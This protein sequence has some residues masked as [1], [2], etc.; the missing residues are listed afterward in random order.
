MLTLIE[1]LLFA[2]RREGFSISTAQ[3]IDAVK[4]IELV[5]F[6]DRGTVR[7]ALQAIVVHQAS[8]RER[9]SAA[10]DRFFSV[11]GAHAGDLF[12][13]LLARGFDASEI[14]ML[15]ELVDRFAER[16]SSG[17]AAI[18]ALV[19]PPSELDHLLSIARVRREVD[20]MTSPSQ[21]G[22]FRER[23]SDTLG[24]GAASTV[25]AAIGRAL[26][27]ALGERGDALREALARE[28][29][30]MKGRIHAHVEERARAI[31]TDVERP[32]AFAS[33]SSDEAREMRVAVRRIAE[34]LRGKA[35]VRRRRAR[36]GRIDAARTIRRSFATGG[37][38]FALIR[39][40][41][42][43]D[44]PKLVVVCDISESVRSASSFMLEF[45]AVVSDLL[46]DVRSFVFVSDLA[47]TS[48]LFATMPPARA[49]SAIAS[50]SVISL[51]ATSSYGRALSLLEQATR[52]GLDCRTTL[53]ILG[54]GRTNHKA[55]GADI[56]AR[57]ARRARAVLWI[58]PEAR[59]SW[60]SGD[61]RMPVYAR[62]ATVLEA[63]TVR[64]L[65][66]AA[67]A[68]LAVR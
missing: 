54:D 4:A 30:E 28:I 39:R 60:G 21:V 48:L 23:V 6:D 22:F 68:L 25:M 5:G 50:G 27:D 59:S 20:R 56:L 15:R 32:F 49:L 66:R 16:T 2:L 1:E 55:D 14:A 9:F 63:R 38:P 13:R 36:R 67:R 52:H 3:A 47:E 37:V 65:E 43:R 42:R 10:F 12:A 51:G 58:C 40:R 46:D 33:L 41:P 45:V 17:D 61:S 11:A 31:T 57:L 29:A 8:D 62:H 19:G 18:R 64:E 7:S 44:R 53:A 35:Q 34:K 26:R 24:V